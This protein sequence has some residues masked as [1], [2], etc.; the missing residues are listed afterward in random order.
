MGIVID[1]SALVALER[2]GAEWELPDPL[3]GVAVALPAIV[4]A[5]LV[6]GVHLANTPARASSRRAKVSAL[7]SRVPV[8][9]FGTAIAERWGELFATL[10]RAGSPI[11]SN[12]LAVAATAHFLGFGVLVGPRGEE[13]F[14]R[15]PDLR[16]HAMGS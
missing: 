2:A 1:T 14:S 13:H 16:V 9:E 15:V 8:V 10:S 7:V 11:S 6:S 12:D 5:E 3:L 4:L